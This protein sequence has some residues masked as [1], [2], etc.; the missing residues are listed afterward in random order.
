MSAWN[1]SEEEEE[2]EVDAGAGAGVSAEAAEEVAGGC[3]VGSE[4]GVSGAGVV[5]TLSL[6]C[7]GAGSVDMVE[8]GMS[9]RVQVCK[10][11]AECVSVSVS[12]RMIV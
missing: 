8:E 3:E 1:G 7:A 2:G 5:M 4:E 9:E 10:K 12:S 11:K 6:S